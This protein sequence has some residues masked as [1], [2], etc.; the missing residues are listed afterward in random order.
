MKISKETREIL[1]KITEHNYADM[2]GTSDYDGIAEDVF[3]VLSGREIGYRADCN[4]EIIVDPQFSES[5][6][7]P[8]DDS[9]TSIIKDFDGWST[10]K[11]QLDKRRRTPQFNERDIW[12]CQ[13]GINIGF[14][15]DGKSEIYSRPVLILSRINEW[16]FFGVPLTS[17]DKEGYYYMKVGEIEPGV[18]STAILSQAR[19]F[20]VNRLVER[21]GKIG[22]KRF[23]EIRNSTAKKVL[24]VFSPR[25][26]TKGAAPN[27]DLYPHYSKQTA[28]SQDSNAKRG[29]K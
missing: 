7:M 19:V 8:S 2:S 1:E 29:R 20:S 11:K 21:I 13:I 6:H 25:I 9:A 27:G 3:N 26:S 15:Q 22:T 14:E 17:K 18:T 12:W 16:M 28:K 10:V 24:K 5:L 23:L 4:H